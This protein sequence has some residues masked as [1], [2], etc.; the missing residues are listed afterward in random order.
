MLVS[1]TDSHLLFLSPI[2]Q[3]AIVDVTVNVTRK[4]AQILNAGKD[5]SVP[6][7]GAL[8]TSFRTYLMHIFSLK[9][10]R[11]RWRT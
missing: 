11:S 3:T 2:P 6:S 10:P 7:L 5:V 9:R 1:F 8:T 4:A